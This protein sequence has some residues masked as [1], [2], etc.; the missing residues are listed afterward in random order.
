[1]IGAGTPLNRT[2]A[3]L[4]LVATLPLAS[5]CNPAGVEGPMF[6]PNTVRI[7]PGATV[8]TVCDAPLTIETPKG[9]PACGKVGRAGVTLRVT[10]T[11]TEFGDPGGAVIV[12]VPSYVPGGKFLAS[13]PMYMLP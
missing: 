8:P 3:P 9:G 10:G 2:R 4:T 6:W 13:A 11:L 7:S 5:S 1:M 12:T